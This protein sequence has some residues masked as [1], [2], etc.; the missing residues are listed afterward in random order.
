MT[1]PPV[2]P[3]TI[4]A[5]PVEIA[6]QSMPEANSYEVFAVVGAGAGVGVDAVTVRTQ[7]R[8]NMVKFST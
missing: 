1:V 2:E 5:F 4:Y 8:C 3:V 6:T 7:K